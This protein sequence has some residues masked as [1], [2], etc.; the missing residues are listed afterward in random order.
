[1]PFP[2][3][4][5]I[6]PRQS[7]VV[8]LDNRAEGNAG[9]DFEKE[10]GDVG[11]LENAMRTIEEEHISRAKLIEE[12]EVHVFEWLAQNAVAESVDVGARVGINR[13]DLDR[14]VG[15]GSGVVRDPCRVARADFEK[16]R[17]PVLAEHSV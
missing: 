12:R 10:D 16:A 1:G 13:H 17:R 2:P 7:N 3:L 11:I 9:K 8:N 5:R 15:G 6:I 14:N 4:R